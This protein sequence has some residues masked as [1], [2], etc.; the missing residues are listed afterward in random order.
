MEGAWPPC[1]NKVLEV[2]LPTICVVTRTVS[3][4]GRSTNKG[5]LLLEVELIPYCTLFYAEL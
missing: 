1:T 4:N 3:I 2:E 5:C